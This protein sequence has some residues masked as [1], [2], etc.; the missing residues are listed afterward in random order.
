MISKLAS[1]SLGL[2]ILIFIAN[3]L[4]NRFFWYDSLWWFDMPMH[5]LGGF[6]VATLT[7][8]VFIKWNSIKG[9]SHIRIRSIILISFFSALVI[10]IGWEIF[11]FIVDLFYPLAHMAHVLD[12]FSDLF[13]DASGG[14]CAALYVMYLSRLYPRIQ[15]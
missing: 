1:R 8:L 3:T 7:L 5:F 14:M 12:S 10:G 4:A 15:K 13:F 6:I 11:E 9:D 2:L